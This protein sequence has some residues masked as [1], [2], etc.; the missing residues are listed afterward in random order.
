MK[1]EI[2]NE[3]DPS[4][5]MILPIHQEG[6]NMITMACGTCGMASDAY[7]KKHNR[8]HTGFADK[9]TACLLCINA[10][11]DEKRGEADAI[12]GEIKKLFSDYDLE[13]L[14]DYAEISS[15][16][17]GDDETVSIVRFLASKA[18][19]TK[20]SFEVAQKTLKETKSINYLM[21]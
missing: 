6:G 11:V 19:R 5:L 15:R 12:A 3:K 14:N 20:V 7:C 16:L 17:T 18:E 9:T 4:T 1:C 21:A 10:I 8:I 2:C 13:F